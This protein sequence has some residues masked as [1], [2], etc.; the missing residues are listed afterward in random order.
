MW[1]LPANTCSPAKMLPNY[2]STLPFA[3][4]QLQRFYKACPMAGYTAGYNAGKIEVGSLRFLAENKLIKP[5]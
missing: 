1:V 5:M 3:A 4:T 2:I